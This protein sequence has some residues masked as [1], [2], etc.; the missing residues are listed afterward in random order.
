IYEAIQKTCWFMEG[1]RINLPIF[2]DGLSWG[3]AQCIGDAKVKEQRPALLIELPEILDRWYKPPR[4]GSKPQPAGAMKALGEWVFKIAAQVI[5][6]ELKALGP[7]FRLPAGRDVDA[8]QLTEQGLM[9]MRDIMKAEA[10]NLWK[11]LNDVMTMD[12]SAKKK[13]PDK[14]II[15]VISMAAYHRSHHSN[16]LQKLLAI[17]LKFRGV[18]AKGFD[19]L[20]AMGFVMS[21]KWACE[22]IDRMSKQ[23]LDEVVR[24]IEL[25]P[26]VVSYDNV[27]IPFRVFSQRLD[28]QKDPGAS[29]AATVYIK[30][31]AQQL[32]ES[33]NA[34][35]KETR[36]AGIEKPL[37]EETILELE[38]NSYPLIK[39]Q[40]EYIVLRMLLDSP[41]FDLTTY[42]H[43][44]SD[45][46]NPPPALDSL[47]TGPDH[48]TLQY[49][50]GTVDIPEASYEDNSR[51]VNEWFRQ[52]GF[53]TK[54]Q[55]VKLA[56]EK[57]VTWV[58][59]QLT[60]DR[61][62]HLFIR[63]ADD[64]NSFDRMDYATFVF[65]WLHLQM[66]LANSLHKQ[67]FG[68]TG[69]QGLK[70][71]FELLNKKQLNTPRTQG[72][73]H[74]DVVEAISTVLEAH[75]YED[76]VRVAGVHSLSDLH[77]C[78]APELKDLAAELV[79]TG[80]SGAVMDGITHSGCPDILRQ[81]IILFCRDAL[82]YAVLDEAIKE[83]DVGMMEAML[84]LP[85]LFFHF[86]GGGN[87]KYAI[88]VLEL[89][90]GLYVEW[91]QEVADFVWHH[92]W[93]VNS[94]GH[95]RSFCPINKA[96]E[97]NIKDIKVTYRS[98]GPNIKWPYLRKLHPAIPIIR[99]VINF[100]EHQFGTIVRGKKHSVPSK[101]KDI[102]KLRASFSSSKL[103][104]QQP[105]R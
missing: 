98:E 3:N 48:A 49:L 44:R 14:I 30:Q 34:L 43:R 94:S 58:G 4:T 78:T 12:T 47:P 50:L 83:G 39:R 76:W 104:K 36:K 8:E 38:H 69:G 41:D 74:H 71:A 86:V 9:E 59:D 11:I 79:Q 96:Q 28:N 32:S 26:W 23:A 18:S 63:R 103:H 102:A 93:L 91:P 2:L 72:P 81:Q 21:H 67:F 60:V 6:D 105:G 7:A 54:E 1:Q 45:V 22:V 46:L 85:T 64:D 13:D 37:T 84:L 56:M 25:F 52:L 16:R 42:K 35:L 99:V 97:M 89:M 10:P 31:D 27:N 19:T 40:M 101:E 88:E 92:C 100:I 77:D 33:I 66:A 90:Q 61:L 62:R 70:Q 17:Y 80:A 65:G 68:T 73:F 82:Q 95:P 24:L 75:I 20:H 51:L 87:S 57:I 29:T 53:N 55:K 5:T 15:A